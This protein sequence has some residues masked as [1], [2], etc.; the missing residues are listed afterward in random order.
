MASVSYNARERRL[1]V[2]SFC[3]PED[4]PGLADAI[5]AFA[6]P[7]SGLIVDLTRMP[8]VPSEVAVA[9]R[10]ACRG[11]ESL[12]CRVRVWTD[13]DTATAA[14]ISSARHDVAAS[15]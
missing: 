9:I 8:S 13:P 6:D 4:A 15:S 5:E 14:Q 7:G 1:V 3:W 11:A 12:G 10:D 2:E